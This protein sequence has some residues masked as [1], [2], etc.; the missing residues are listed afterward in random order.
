MNN[1]G[2]LALYTDFEQTTAH[3]IAL[4]R[5][6]DTPSEKDLADAV[7]L[8]TNWNKQRQKEGLRLWQ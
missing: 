8:T 1:Q 4:E 6:R 2:D 5:N 3:Q 7:K